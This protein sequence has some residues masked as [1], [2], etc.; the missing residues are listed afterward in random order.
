MLRCVKQSVVQGVMLSVACAYSSKLTTRLSTTPVNSSGA[1]CL[2]LKDWPVGKVK[3]RVSS[4]LGAS[5]DFHD[6]VD[7]LC[8][9]W[10]VTVR[11]VAVS[12]TETC[13]AV[14]RERVCDS[15][16]TAAYAVIWLACKAFWVSDADQ[17]VMQSKK[18]LG[19]V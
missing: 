18:S 12:L 11:A 17:A 13:F 15:R 2:H 7:M 19:S 1:D 6:T 4:A 8:L 9:L 16:L 10:T 3:F 14:A 5:R